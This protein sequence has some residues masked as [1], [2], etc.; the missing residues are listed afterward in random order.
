MCVYCNVFSTQVTCCFNDFVIGA[1][2][3]DH[4]FG[5]CHL[6]E[7][8][9]LIMA[10]ID[11]SID[12]CCSDISYSMLCDREIVENLSYV[13]LEGS[14]GDFLGKSLF[15]ATKCLFLSLGC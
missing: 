8:H 13:L 11:G 9:L 12:K 15:T 14:V 5:M 10:G 6:S 3:P 7:A 2:H 4:L 1:I